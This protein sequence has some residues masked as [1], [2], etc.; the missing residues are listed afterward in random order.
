[1]LARS[2]VLLQESVNSP[3]RGRCS[4]YHLHIWWKWDLN[5]FFLLFVR[6]SWQGSLAQLLLLGQYYQRFLKAQ[7]I[8]HHWISRIAL[9]DSRDTTNAFYCPLINTTHSSVILLLYT[10]T[11]LIKCNWTPWEVSVFVLTSPLSAASCLSESPFQRTAHTA[12]QARR[13]ISILTSFFAP[14]TKMK[15][16]SMPSKR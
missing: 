13:A 9:S 14:P 4:H 6:K 15:E 8:S 1:M 11:A 16:K 5:S 2:P 7:H 3:A 12:I 10:V